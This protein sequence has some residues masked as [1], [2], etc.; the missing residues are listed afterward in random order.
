MASVTTPPAGQSWERV[1]RRNPP[2]KKDSLV[3]Q[4]GN[5]EKECL[6]SL[7]YVLTIQC[8]FGC[9]KFRLIICSA[10]SNQYS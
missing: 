8:M 6:A 4:M 5:A 2:E 7:E 3:V 1:S 9:G 10:L